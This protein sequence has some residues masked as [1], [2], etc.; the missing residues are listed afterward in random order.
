MSKG[1]I[2]K[3]IAVGF[4]IAVIFPM[5]MHYGARTLHAP[6]DWDDY[7]TVQRPFNPN[8]TPEE[9]EQDEAERQAER[10][11]Y[12]QAEKDF[13]K[14]LFAVT[15]PAGLAAIIAG[16]I[17]PVAAIGAGLIFGGIFSLID[18]YV[19]FWSELPDF[20]RFFSLLGGFAVLL[21]VG[22]KKIKN[23]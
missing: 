18:G 2:A 10:K 12:R 9:R 4:G 13:Q 7:H 6:P 5:L 11:K 1:L 19:H 21:F 20:M 17:I 3:K 16:A 22:F 8:M 15:V 23:D 14:V